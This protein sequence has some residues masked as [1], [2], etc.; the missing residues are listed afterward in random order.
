MRKV[1]LPTEVYVEIGL[2]AAKYFHHP[3]IGYIIGTQGD[4]HVITVTD[5][6]PI[7]HSVPAGPILE[8]AGEIVRIYQIN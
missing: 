5:V 3:V 1:R 7:G 8:I 4:G 6:L 2:H